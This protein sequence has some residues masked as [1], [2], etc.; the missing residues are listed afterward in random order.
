MCNCRRAAGL[1]NNGNFNYGAFNG[2][3]KYKQDV[4]IAPYKNFLERYG[5]FKFTFSDRGFRV[6]NDDDKQ[7]HYCKHY[8]NGGVSVILFY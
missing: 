5:G 2:I 6:L 8:F 3:P 1:I 7:E 4:L